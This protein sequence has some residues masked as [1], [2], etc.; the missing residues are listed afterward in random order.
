[1]DYYG[2]LHEHFSFEMIIASLS[3]YTYKTISVADVVV[4]KYDRK[5]GSDGI[6][7]TW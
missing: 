6:P 7:P 2:R 3:I 4:F 5:S 1:M